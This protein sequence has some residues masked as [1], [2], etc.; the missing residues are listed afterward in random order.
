MNVKTAGAVMAVAL[1]TAGS[2]GAGVIRDRQENQEQRIE[3]GVAS[4]Q[5]TGR[6]AARLE[7]QDARID[8]RAERARA[9]GVV[10]PGEGAR[11]TR[12]QN[13]ASRHIYRQKHDRQ[14]R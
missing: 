10:T 7:R 13:R 4:G 12:Q 9:D 6:E 11:L 2:A 1:I 14:T 5:L 3:N 8:R